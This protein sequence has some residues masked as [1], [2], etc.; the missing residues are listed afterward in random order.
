MPKAPVSPAPWTPPAGAAVRAAP[1]APP[2][3]T[4]GGGGTPGVCGAPPACRGGCSPVY[5]IPCPAGRVCDDYYDGELRRRSPGPG[6]CGGG[7]SGGVALPGRLRLRRRTGCGDV[8]RRAG[9]GRRAAAPAPRSNGA[10]CPAGVRLRPLPSTGPASRRRRPGTS[11]AAPAPR[12]TGSPARPDASATA[13]SPELASRRRRRGPAAAAAHRRAESTVRPAASA[14]V[15]A[16]GPASRRRTREPVGAPAP[17]PYGIPLPGRLRLRRRY[18]DGRL[19]RGAGSR[20]PVR[21]RLLPALRRGRLPGRVCL[22][23]LPSTGPA[24]RAPAPGQLRGSAASPE[25]RHRLPGRLRLR[26]LPQ[27]G[28]HQRAAAAA[29]RATDRAARRRDGA[30]RWTV[31]GSGR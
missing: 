9:A 8:R 16:T 24:S 17:R 13:I 6:Q 3:R 22:R 15:P 20:E 2:P 23:P 19:R 14:T 18:V 28:L 7:C 21:R 27:R 29:P 10:D 30:V 5:S 12:P 4:C 31:T 1:P 11:A 26:P 25:P